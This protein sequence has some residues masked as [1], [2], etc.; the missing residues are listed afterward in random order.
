MSSPVQASVVP[1]PVAVQQGVPLAVAPLTEAQLPPGGLVIAP[2]PQSSLYVG[3]LDP[4]VT[5]AMLFELFSMVGPVAS[6]RVCRDTIT[7]R[8]L[9][10]A[11][12]NFHNN[13]ESGERA[14]ETLNYTVL[15]GRP[16]R[17]MWSNRDPTLR[18][19]GT[20]NIFIKNLDESIDNKAL[21]DTFSAFG[22]ILSCKVALDE[23]G[24][25]KGYG[26]V[27]YET[28]ESAESAIKHVNG[29]LLND[30]QVFVG[31][32]VARK[33]RQSKID[34]LRGQFTNIY[35]KNLDEAVTDEQFQE[36][37]GAFGAI[38]S[39][40]VSRDEAGKSKGFGFVNFEQHEDARKAVEEMH[41]KEINGKQI[42]VGRAKKKAEREEE[43]RKEFEKSR[44]E[45]MNKYQGVNLYVKNLDESIDDESLR[46]EF[47]PFGTIT[48]AKIM[49]DDAKN[50]S[51]GF[52]FVCFSSPDEA[53]KA[54]SEMNGKVI[55]GKP[56][57]VALA[58]RK[59]V[60]RAYL[61]NQMQQRAQ[62]RMQQPIPAGFP[63]VFFPPPNGMVPPQQQRGGFFPPGQ[64]GGP[65]PRWAPNG[66]IPAGFPNQPMP[67]GQFAGQPG[68]G[69]PGAR[70]Q[71]GRGAPMGMPTGG[72]RPNMPPNGQMQPTRGGRGGMGGPGYKFGQNAR[73]MPQQQPMAP[74]GGAAKPTLNAATLASMAPE[75]QK[76]MLGEAL[77][78]MI[79]QQSRSLAGKVTGMLLEMDN[80]ELLH[81]LESPEALFG[82]VAEA[83]LVLEEHMQIAQAE[84]G[85]PAEEN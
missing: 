2:T 19:S 29:M 67:M 66:Q 9:G 25:S 32:H 36:M 49:V 20:G 45:K 64:M 58:Q 57:F 74:A 48:S 6:I 26:F 75:Q 10:Y 62:M 46:A 35:C 61:S 13:I 70:Q 68:R 78:P 63:G 81:L 72:P 60:R 39:A 40:V 5:E 80:G 59:D 43:L 14:M 52:G 73:N 12:V 34:E 37:F 50:I 1:V 77:F 31:L 23:S 38:V 56:I 76:R 18:R 8:S 65:R 84:G 82:K 44:E 42:Y 24:N 51:R 11:Y 4:S 54:V 30:K 21:H 55:N 79:Q 15:K 33:E 27:H 71:P 69:G 41:E 7:R 28:L 16:I 53:T 83:V 85:K 17:I 22:N 3:E 47:A